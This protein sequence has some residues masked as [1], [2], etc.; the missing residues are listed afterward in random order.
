MTMRHTDRHED[1]TLTTCPT[2]GDVYLYWQAHDH[3]C[4]VRG[5]SDF[6][7]EEYDEASPTAI[8]A[9]ARLED[10]CRECGRLHDGDC[11]LEDTSDL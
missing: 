8:E 10:A 4:R 9:L 5:W 11:A 1:D 3:V 7:V 6:P 2:C